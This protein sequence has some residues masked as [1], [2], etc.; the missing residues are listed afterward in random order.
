MQL[1]E[2]I[3][4][5]QL[6]SLTFSQVF[7]NLSNQGN[8][9]I[10][11]MPQLCP[12]C[13]NSIHLVQSSPTV[14]LLCKGCGTFFDASLQPAGDLKAGLDM[15][16]I[17]SSPGPAPSRQEAPATPLEQEAEQPAKRTESMLSL[18]SSGGGGAYGS[19]F[20]CPK[21]GNGMKS[22]ESPVTG[23]TLYTCAKCGYTGTNYVKK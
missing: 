13:Q 6:I 14:I 2:I 8:N 21:C 19:T 22:M 10:D 20:G 12:N 1:R 3:N 18:L 9:Y 4:L 5:G 16:R 15:D 17:S 23:N 11:R 7:T